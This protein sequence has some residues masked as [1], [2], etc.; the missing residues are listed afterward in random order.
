MTT[1]WL[2]NS[3]FGWIWVFI[4]NLHW[5]GQFKF[6]MELIGQARLSLSLPYAGPPTTLSALLRVCV[7]V[8]RPLAHSGT[9]ASNLTPSFL[10][11][12]FF[13]GPFFLERAERPNATR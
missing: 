2:A 3:N 5:L 11:V 10:E 4:W 9:P 8:S 13:E 12:F 7:H 6:R 1:D